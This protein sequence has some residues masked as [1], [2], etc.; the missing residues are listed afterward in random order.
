MLHLD[1]WRIPSKW[2]R[3]AAREGDTAQL[4]QEWNLKYVAETR[5]KHTLLEANLKTFEADK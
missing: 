4:D 3:E 2:A 5:T 1:P